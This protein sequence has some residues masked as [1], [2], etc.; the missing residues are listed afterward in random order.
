MK[1][2]LLEKSSVLVL[3]TDYQYRMVGKK[4][5]FL[6]FTDVSLLFTHS[7]YLTYKRAL[8]GSFPYMATFLPY[9]T[10]FWVGELK[11]VNIPGKTTLFGPGLHCGNAAGGRGFPSL[12][13]FKL[14]A[15]QA[16]NDNPDKEGD[17]E[18]DASDVESEALK[19]AFKKWQDHRPSF[20]EMHAEDVKRRPRWDIKEDF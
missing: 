9:V 11:P 20:A 17:E 19:K 7:C 6:C 16:E 1:A 2:G 14:V 18:N 12:Q 13:K 5:C 15:S 10:T 8:V 4:P 3:K